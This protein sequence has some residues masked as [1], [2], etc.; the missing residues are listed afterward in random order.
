MSL[1]TLFHTVVLTRRR[2]LVSGASPVNVLE[3]DDVVL[4]EI[5][6]G[7]NLDQERRDFAWIG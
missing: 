4:V 3:P 6:P 7:L 2:V 5:G 1:P